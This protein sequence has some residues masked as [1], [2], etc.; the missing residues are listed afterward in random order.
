MLVCRRSSG[1]NV[2]DIGQILA[3]LFSVAFLRL[4][5]QLGV[6]SLYSDLPAPCQLG[7]Y[8]QG[9]ILFTFALV[10]DLSLPVRPSLA[11]ARLRP[12]VLQLACFPAPRGSGRATA[13]DQ[14]LIHEGP[15]VLAE[16]GQLARLRPHCRVP[17]VRCVD[18][19]DQA[20]LHQRLQ[21]RK[22]R[23]LDRVRSRDRV[24]V[25]LPVRPFGLVAW[26]KLEL[27]GGVVEQ[28]REFL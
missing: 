20:H 23:V 2:D 22:V 16:D 9:S 13:S 21:H 11:R 6:G 24:V 25:L 12:V 14:V 15:I 3:Y 26:I 28:N 10:V 8:D 19:T 17:H 27:R 7:G 1:E 5:G 18:R 4:F